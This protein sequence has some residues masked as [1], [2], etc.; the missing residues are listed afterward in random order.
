LK[1]RICAEALEPRAPV[2]GIAWARAR[3]TVHIYGN[4]KSENKS[5]ADHEYSGRTFTKEAG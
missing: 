5:V 4:G 3:E 2:K 1:Y